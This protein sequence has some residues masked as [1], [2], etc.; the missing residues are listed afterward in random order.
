[1]NGAISVHLK[2]LD[3]NTNK[4]AALVIIQTKDLVVKIENEFTV[5]N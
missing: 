3:D 4:I 1:M 2:S 5:G